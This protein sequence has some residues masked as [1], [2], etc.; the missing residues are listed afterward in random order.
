MEKKKEPAGTNEHSKCQR[1]RGAHGQLK[2]GG[3]NG[4][5]ENKYSLGWNWTRSVIVPLPYRALRTIQTW[6]ITNLQGRSL[7]Q[8]K[9]NPPTQRLIRCTMQFSYVASARTKARSTE[10][11]LHLPFMCPPNFFDS[12]YSPVELQASGNQGQM[13]TQ[14][15]RQG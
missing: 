15:R 14:S 4:S 3:R 9:K 7:T 2:C 11:T 12:D 8:I 6:C 5:D 13:T 1:L 10:V